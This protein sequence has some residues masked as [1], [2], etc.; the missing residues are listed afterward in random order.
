MPADLVV[1][2]I[3]FNGDGTP[4]DVENPARALREAG[5]LVQLEERGLPCRDLGD[6]AVPAAEGR[7][8]PHT[9]VLNVGAWQEVTRRTLDAVRPLVRGGAFPLV[10][11]G[12]CGLLVGLV[13]ACKR[14]GLAVGLVSLDGHADCRLPWDS[15]TGEPADLPLAILTGWG[16]AELTRLAGPPPLLEHRDVAVCGYREPDR[17]EETAIPRLDG[18]EVRRRGAEAAARWCLDVLSG[19]PAVWLHLDVDVL[20]PSVMPVLFPEPGGLTLEELAPLLGA[21][22]RS[23]RVVGLDVACYHPALDPG[24]AAGRRLVRVLAE[25][26]AGFA[27]GQ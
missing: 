4:P 7:R 19:R 20:D 26:L 23:G 22:L 16:P 13:G 1:L 10:L 18:P 5:L 21:I 14:E 17:I 9:G 27:H 2:G 25:S 6:V 15:P 24:L 8:D 12:D 11:G 3:P